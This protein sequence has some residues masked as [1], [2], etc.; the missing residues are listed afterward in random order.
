MMTC[1]TLYSSISSR[2][3]YTSGG[4]IA[5]SA[6]PLPASGAS[7]RFIAADAE[8]NPSSR[9]RVIALERR[10]SASKKRIKL[11]L[12]APASKSSAKPVAA[13]QSPPLWA[14]A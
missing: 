4:T 13:S 8:T 6:E 10:V 1:S 11:R 2:I 7:S 5:R 12:R 3:A 14:W 9:I